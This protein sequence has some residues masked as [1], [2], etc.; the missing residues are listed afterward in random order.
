MPVAMEAFLLVILTIS[1]C[2]LTYATVRRI[3][4]LRPFFGLKLARPASL[5]K[6]GES[7]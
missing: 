2:W 3:P 5:E 1:G 7:A 6:K 4:L